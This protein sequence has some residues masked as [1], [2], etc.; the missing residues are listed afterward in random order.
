MIK[1]SIYNGLGSLIVDIEDTGI[2]Q[3]VFNA[4]KSGDVMK[5][6]EVTSNFRKEHTMLCRKMYDFVNMLDKISPTEREIFGIKENEEKGIFIYNPEEINASSLFIFAYFTGFD[7]STLFSCADMLEYYEEPI[8]SD[9]DIFYNALEKESGSSD[10]ARFAK[11]ALFNEDHLAY[12]AGEGIV[13]NNKYELLVDVF[14]GKV[15]AYM[16]N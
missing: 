14:A 7:E 3:K 9:I 16:N 15:K 4:A 6:I 13:Y 11:V 2:A 1:K 5:V 10:F 12:L 8:Y